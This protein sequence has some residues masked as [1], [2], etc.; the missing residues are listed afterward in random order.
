MPGPD[1]TLGE[2][3]FFL[4]MLTPGSWGLATSGYN[5]LRQSDPSHYRAAFL[6]GVVPESAGDVRAQY[7]SPH[8]TPKQGEECAA[9]SAQPQAQPA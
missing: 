3:P 7:R 1:T 9:S 6:H 2:Q 5:T 4:L 8:A